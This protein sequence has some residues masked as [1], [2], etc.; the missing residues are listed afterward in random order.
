MHE[1][2]SRIITPVLFLKAIMASC[3]NNGSECFQD[4]NTPYFVADYDMN[5]LE[6]SDN[7]FYGYKALGELTN[8]QISEASG[9]AV[10][11][12]DKSLIWTHNNRGD[13]NRIFLIG[14]D[15]TFRGAF[16]LSGTGNRDWED[17]AIGPGPID[18]VNYLYIADIGDNQFEYEIKYIYRLPEPD[19]NLADSSV[20]W[21]E[22]SSAERLPF[23]YPGEKKMDAETLMI[24]PWTKDL[25]VVT[26]REYPITVY[27]IPYP[28]S[29]SDTVVAQKYGTL[30]FT[31]ATAGDISADGQE[32]V[33][34]TKEKVFLWTREDG[35]SVADAFLRQP[36]RL[37]YTSEVQGEAIA[38]PSDGSGYYTLSEAKGGIT[39][40]VYFYK[41][42]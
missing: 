5:S 8:N 14:N 38:F 25:F 11:R 10:S 33:I 12:M 35:E 4:E 17:M 15:G 36:I 6:V 7:F 20:Q 32:I 23:I 16:R 1:K 9:I 19:I 28:Q 40:V 30:P 21:K 3:L 22:I 13:L 27:R 41:R 42:K 29:V 37:P 31:M 39:P 24:D 26:K 34:K 18:L 2:F